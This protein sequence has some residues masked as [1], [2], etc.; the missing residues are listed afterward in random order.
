[1]DLVKDDKNFVLETASEIFCFYCLNKQFADVS[2]LLKG[3]R[4]PIPGHSFVLCSRSEYFSTALFGSSFSESRTKEFKVDATLPVFVCI[5]KHIYT[6]S[7]TIP[8]DLNQVVE[9]IY[10]SDLYLLP[11]LKA[12]CVR[13]IEE[14]LGPENVS[15]L[16]S[17]A[18]K[19][20]ISSG[21]LMKMMLQIGESI[22]RSKDFLLFDSGM[23]IDLISSDNLIASE[24]CIFESCLK[25]VKHYMEDDVKEGFK[26]LIPHIRFPLMSAKDLSTTVAKSGVLEQE[27]LLQLLLYVNSEGACG[28]VKGFNSSRRVEK[29]HDELPFAHLTEGDLVISSNKT[30]R[31]GL[32]RQRSIKI[33]Q[34]AVVTVT[35]FD[36]KEG[37]FV[38]LIADKVILEGSINLDGK[39]YNG[40]KSAFKGQDGSQ[41][42]GWCSS[43]KV[44]R[45]LN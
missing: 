18:M 22:L 34:G 9:T 23:V 31:S 27:E 36:G 21:S 13:Y 11:K 29:P 37:G 38:Y 2:F 5:L 39:G 17:E 40:G 26:E 14:F 8:D 42:Q 6:F 41:Q 35:G 24:I 16:Y 19:W 1:M 43:N 45:N 20:G 33:V 25:Y 32:Y 44:K 15:G 3:V 28:D 10:Y 30:L 4:D 7:C 12:R